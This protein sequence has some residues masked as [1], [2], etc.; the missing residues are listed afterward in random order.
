MPERT[1]CQTILWFGQTMLRFGHKRDAPGPAQ[2]RGHAGGLR[3]GS[4]GQQVREK[5]AFGRGWA[6]ARAACGF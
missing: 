6:F 3:F 1:I 2:R 5:G 4:G